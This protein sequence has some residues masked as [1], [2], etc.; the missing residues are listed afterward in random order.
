MFS[1]KKLTLEDR[2]A[3]EAFT[4]RFTPYSDFNFTS[5][6]SYNTSNDAEFA[7]ADK[8][9]VIKMRNYITN[10]FIYSFLASENCFEIAS[11][12]LKRCLDEGLENK[13]NLVPEQSIDKSLLDSANFIIEED[14]N[15]FDYILSTEKASRLEGATYENKRK[16]TNQFSNNYP[17]CKIKLSEQIEQEESQ[18]IKLLFDKWALSKTEEEVEH[19][20]IALNRLLESR[21]DLNIS[22]LGIWD[23]DQLIGYALV[24]KINQYAM[25]HFMK[26]DSLYKNIYDTLYLELSRYLF[27]SGVV[28]LNYEQDM[29]IEGLR[30]AKMSWH[31]IGFLKKYTI[32]LNNE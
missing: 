5:L 31:P 25:G 18:K 23:S 16:H 17:K 27:Q 14:R 1:F 11:A 21:Q 12:L 13:L 29:G 30:S 9:F 20:R 2:A 32:S 15:S 8:Y 22:N 19:E 7:L 28:H 4:D 6:W 3:I 24:E 10:D 26:A